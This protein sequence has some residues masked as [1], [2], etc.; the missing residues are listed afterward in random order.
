MSFSR[1][2][3]I[4]GTTGKIPVIESSGPMLVANVTGINFKNTGTTTIYTVP[5]IGT[6]AFFPTSMLLY[7]TASNSV[8][9][10]PTIRAGISSSLT[11]LM[12]A[13]AMTG[14]D[15]VGEYLDLL[16]TT[17]KQIKS[18]CP[19]ASVIQIDVTIAAT[20]TTFTGGVALFGYFLG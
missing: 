8:T 15:N 13:T 12:A 16:T 18:G 7:A 19:A 10:V 3:N 2:A 4:D 20:A 11:S 6:S 9:V 1:F 17:A 14:F 5:T